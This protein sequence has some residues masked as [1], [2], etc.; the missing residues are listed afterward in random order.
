MNLTVVAAQE[1]AATRPTDPGGPK[2][3]LVVGNSAYT[4]TSPLKNP[5]NDAKAIGSTLQQLG[6]EVTTLLDVNQRQMEQALRRFGS[7]LRDQN[8]VGLF[9]YAGHGMQVSGENYLLPVDINPSTETDVRYDAI[10][11]GKLLGQM[12]AAGNGMNIVILDACRNNP[13]VRSFRSESRGLAQVIAPTGSFIS[14]ATAPGNVAADGEGDNGL[15]TAK[16]LEHMMRLTGMR[17]SVEL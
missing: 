11:V 1:R 15:F 7:R 10:P 2:Q 14:Y 8:G 13:F 5:V 9:Y 4:H 16:L 17:P 12:E 6:F 3:A